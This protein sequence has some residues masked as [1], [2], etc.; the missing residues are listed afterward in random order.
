MAITPVYST[1]FHCIYDQAE[2]FGRMGSG[3]H[4]SIFR[5]I[6]RLDVEMKPSPVPQI[7]DFAVIWDEDHDQRIIKVVESLLMHDLL[8]PVQFIG[9]R[10][11]TLTIVLAARAVSYMGMSVDQYAAAAS[12]AAQ[13]SGIEDY[14]AP[15]IGI[16]DRNPDSVG[17]RDPQYLIA[18]PV[19]VVMSYLDTI[20]YMWSLGSRPWAPPPQPKF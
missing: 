12:K 15:R 7:H 5:A 11:G 8:A 9:E 3:A 1:F 13:A 4:F 6:E 16:Y 2:G 14:W 17:Q 20:D 19:S 18:E 10:K